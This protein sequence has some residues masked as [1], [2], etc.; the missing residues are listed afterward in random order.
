[1]KKPTLPPKTEIEVVATKDGKEYAT[2]MTK[3]QYDKKGKE[4]RK[5]GWRVLAYQKGFRNKN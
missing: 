1:M 2:H 5:Q 4:L 3:K